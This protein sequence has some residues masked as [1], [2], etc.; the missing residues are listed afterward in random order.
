[1]LIAVFFAHSSLVLQSSRDIKRTNLCVDHWVGFHL[2]V[3]DATDQKLLLILLGSHRVKHLVVLLVLMG[4]FPPTSHLCWVHA[5]SYIWTFRH[6]LRSL[7][8][9]S[10]WITDGGELA[11]WLY[12]H[13]RWDISSL[14]LVAIATC[15]DP[16]RVNLAWV[17]SCHTSMI[18]QIFT[19]RFESEVA[20]F[21][22]VF[23]KIS[24]ACWQIGLR[25]LESSCLIGR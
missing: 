7:S 22:I 4:Q 6:L 2:L 23:D 9:L 24:S 17:R 21:D 19:R 3:V 13:T 14:Q 18:R 12:L 1:M 15:S 20:V 10:I 5:V 25:L 11:N 8:R 16:R